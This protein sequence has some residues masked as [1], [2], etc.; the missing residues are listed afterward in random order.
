MFLENRLQELENQVQSLTERVWVLEKLVNQ[1][2]NEQNSG[3]RSVENTP[4]LYE[5][6]E[7]EEMKEPQRID[8]VDKPKKSGKLTQ[9]GVLLHKQKPSSG[10]FSEEKLA[11]TWFNRLGILAIMLAVGFFLKWSFDNH[12]IGELGRVVIGILIGLGFLGAGE[13]FQRRKFAVYGQGFTGGGIAI[14]YFSVFS[15]FTFY[16]LISQP[17]AFGL[18]VLITLAASLL[19][20]RYDSLAIGILGI[21]GGFA[22]PFLLNDGNSNRTILL[23]YVAILNIGVIGVA[24]YKKWVI[25]NY[26]TFFFTYLTFTISHLFFRSEQFPTLSFV[27]LSLFFLAYLGV[28]LG[29]NV[30]LREKAT[31]PDFALIL[32]NA[33]VYFMLSHELVENY[34]KGYMGYWAVLLGVVYLLLGNWIYKYHK[35]DRNLGLAFLGIAGGFIT[36]AL[37][38]QLSTYWLSVAWA[39]EALIIIALSFRMDEFKARVSGLVVLGLSII[40]LV[41]EPFYITGKEVWIFLPDAAIAYLAVLAVLAAMLVVYHKLRNT[42]QDQRIFLGLII[43]FNLIIIFFFTQE[44]S[45]YYGYRSML[46]V[47]QN[48]LDFMA[49]RNA[50][51]VSLSLI[52]G[53]HAGI[54]IV[55]GFWRRIQGI[56]WFGLGFL[57]LVILKVFLYDLSSLST[58]YRILSF[59]VLGVILLGISWLYQ[60]YKYLILGE[61]PSEKS[62]K[63]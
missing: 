45:A 28:S 6:N 51:D 42:F 48:G 23:T 30:R 3:K 36:L 24:F 11:G 18:M 27:Y 41:N 35:S 10:S 13:V 26:L 50:K 58:P 17:V 47:Q 25:F 21:V 12:L 14:L 57:G 8:S 4:L 60:R 52:W 16:N 29:R 33:G 31:W 59:V 54:L 40:R 38:L 32:A 2:Q 34:W 37:P 7:E 22:T 44:I 53:I 46:K 56:R 5:Q 61:M 43:L 1:Y 15:A 49:Y 19:A 39:L 63:Q 9:V 62:Q 20:I 55:L